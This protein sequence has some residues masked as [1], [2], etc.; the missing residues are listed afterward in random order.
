MAQ[1]VK[2]PLLS[3]LWLGLLLWHRSD[4]CPRNFSS[5]GHGVGQ[6]KQTNKPTIPPHTHTHK[7][8]SLTSLIPLPFFFCLFRAT[9]AAY[10]GYQARGRIGT[11]AS[12]L[13]HSNTGSEPHL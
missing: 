10:G 13:Y 5:A 2:H 3:L 1:W 8:D 12:S 6:N 9:P 7:Q 11:V 4:P